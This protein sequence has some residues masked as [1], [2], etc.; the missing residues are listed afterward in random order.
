MKKIVFEISDEGYEFLKTLANGGAEYRDTEHETKEDFLKSEDH[1][2]HGRSL[3]WFM[4][5]NSGGTYHLIDE[6]I[7]YNLIDSDNESYHMTYELTKFG[8]RV[9]LEEFNGMIGK[10]VGKVNVKSKLN[11]KPFKSGLLNNTVKDV[12]VHPILNIPAYTF[13]EDDS[14][15]ECRRCDEFEIKMETDEG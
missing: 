9:I 3:E 11:C 2:E 7:Q 4:N 13:E 6:L 1:L 10:S 12:I 14:Y 5:R 8:C 15:V